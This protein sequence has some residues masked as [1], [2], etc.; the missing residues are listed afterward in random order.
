M[1]AFSA[2]A[3]TGLVDFAKVADLGL[4]GTLRVR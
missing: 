1:D 4:P 2:F 3:T